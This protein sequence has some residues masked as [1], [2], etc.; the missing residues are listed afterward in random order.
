MEAAGVE[1]DG[2]S[3]SGRESTA[4]S[5]D[6]ALDS[7]QPRTDRVASLATALADAVIGRDEV[8]A[9]RLARDIRE[10]GAG[11][12]ESLGSVARRDAP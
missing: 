8:G 10:L 11:G 9:L 3:V 4:S 5:G 1:G 12:A 7:E 6:P 2:M